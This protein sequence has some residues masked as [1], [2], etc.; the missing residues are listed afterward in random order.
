MAESMQRVMLHYTRDRALVGFQK[1]EGNGEA[2]IYSGCDDAIT[3]TTALPESLVEESF[4]FL[5]SLDPDTLSLS[6]GA[7]LT[8]QL[9]I[10]NYLA[11][12]FQRR[13]VADV[14][15][16]FG[17]EVWQRY[18]HRS[19]KMDL[20]GIMMDG[21]PVK[22]HGVLVEKMQQSGP[23]AIDVA[24]KI[25]VAS[26]MNTPLKTLRCEGFFD[27]FVLTVGNAIEAIT[28]K[29]IDEEITAA[30]ILPIEQM[31]LPKV[32]EV[33]ATAIQGN[34][35][36]LERNEAL[37]KYIIRCQN[38]IV[39]EMPEAVRK[40]VMMDMPPVTDAESIQGNVDMM[41]TFAPEIDDPT[42]R[43]MELML[44]HKTLKEQPPEIQQEAN[45][46]DIIVEASRRITCVHIAKE[47]KIGPYTV[48]NSDFPQN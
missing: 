18:F 13:F 11:P 38:Y 26:L 6:D 12:K 16:P 21:Y 42:E 23:A 30:W 1:L 40:R 24:E 22:K 44:L 45:M 19:I 3:T 29:E 35:S 43:L 27:S 31:P 20:T 48:G 28:T 4:E 7:L 17:I 33:L 14:C 47:L 9:K 46:E 37:D 2:V 39:N 8:L 25:L 36:H 32:P 34:Q 5:K 41:M 10:H 15:L